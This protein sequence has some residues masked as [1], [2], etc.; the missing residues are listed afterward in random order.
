MEL[1][2]YPNRDSDN[3]YNIPKVTIT[4]HEAGELIEIELQNPS[5]TLRFTRRDLTRAAK[6]FADDSDDG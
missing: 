1:S 5:R 3:S 2:L 4:E 6:F